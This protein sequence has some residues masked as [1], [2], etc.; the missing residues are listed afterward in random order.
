MASNSKTSTITI[1]REELAAS[2]DAASFEVAMGAIE[3]ALH[4]PILMRSIEDSKAK[5][6]WESRLEP[7]EHQVRNLITFCRRAPVALLADDVG[8]GKTIS[9]GL[10]LSELIARERV[11]RALIVAPKLLLPQWKEELESKFAIQAEAAAGAGVLAEFNGRATAVITT[12]HTFGKHSD[13]IA[14]SAFDMVVF[15]EAHKLRNLF[16]TAAPP[17][18][19]QAA[20]ACLR[21]RKFGYVLMLTA[22]PIQNRVW[23]LYSLVSLLTCANGH[24]NPLGTEAQFRQKFIVTEGG[25][26]ALNQRRRGEFQAEV[27]KYIARTRR[28]DVKLQFPER[29]VKKRAVLPTPTEKQLIQLIAELSLKQKRINALTRVNLGT[30]LMSSP[31]ALLAQLRNMAE[32]GTLPSSYADRAAA[33]VGEGTGSAKLNALLKLVGELRQHNPEHWR[34]VVFTSRKVTQD[35]IVASLEEAEI[36]VGA[37]RG[38][39]TAA[40]QA[41]IEAFR[42][43]PPGVRVL[44]SGE[45]GS[46]GVNLQVANVLVNF[47]LPWNPMT[48]EQRIGRVQRLHS[49]HAEVVVWNLV[50]EGTVEELVVEKLLHKLQEV[51][52]SIGDVEAILEAADADDESEGSLETQIADLVFRSLQGADVEAGVKAAVESIKKAKEVYKDEQKTVEKTLGDLSVFHEQGPALPDIPEFVPS[53]DAAAWVERAIVADGGR[54]SRLA[55]DLFEVR[56]ASGGGHVV[57][58]RESGVQQANRM[59]LAPVKELWPGTR[60]FV[61]LAQRVAKHGRLLVH[62]SPEESEGIIENA[63]R[64]WLTPYTHLRLGRVT[65]LQR[66]QRFAGELSIVAGAHTSYDRIERVVRATIGPEMLG[67]LAEGWQGQPLASSSQAAVATVHQ[68]DAIIAQA[69]EQ[70]PALSAF[71]SFYCQRLEQEVAVAA[72]QSAQYVQSK[73][74]VHRDAT[75]R[76]ARL[77]RVVHSSV[78]IVMLTV[79]GDRVETTARYTSAYAPSHRLHMEEDWDACELTRSRFPRSFLASCDVSGRRVAKSELEVCPVTGTRMCRVLMAP[80]EE[81][82]ELVNPAGLVRCET[83]GRTARGDLVGASAVSGKRCLLRLLEGCRFSGARCLPSELAVSEISDLAYRRDQESASSRSGLRGHL[84]EFV[85]TEEPEGLG[86]RSE[87]AQSSVS[88]RWGF[89]GDMVQSGTGSG[90]LG[91]PSE[92]IQCAATGVTVLRDEVEKSA[93][94]GLEAASTALV[95]CEL[96]GARCLPAE[97]SQSQIS[98]RLVRRDQLAVSVVTQLAGHVSEFVQTRRGPVEQSLAARSAVGGEWAVSAD[99]VSSDIDATRKAFSDQM[100]TSKSTGRRCLPDEAHR[101]EMSGCPGLPDEMCCCAVTGAKLLP[102]ETVLSDVS[103]C[104]VR[105][106]QVSKS[107]KSGRVGHQSEFVLC[108]QSNTLLAA[109]EAARS[110]YSGEWGDL[111]LMARSDVPPGRLGFAS[112]LVRSKASSRRAFPDEVRTSTLSGAYMLPDEGRQCSFTGALGLPDEMLQSEVSHGWYRRDQMV[113]C[114]ETGRCGHKSEFVKSSDPLGWIAKDAAV[115]SS[116]SGEWMARS[117]SVVS[118]TGSGRIG[119]K[120]EAA[121][122]AASGVLALRDEVAECGVSGK[123]VCRE[124]LQP[125]AASGTLALPDQMVTCAE[126]GNRLLPSETEVCAVSGKRVDLRRLLPS[127][128][129]GRLARES[130]MLRCPQSGVRLLPDEAVLCAVSGKRVAPKVAVVCAVSGRHAIADQ[131]ECCGVTGERFISDAKS[132]EVVLGRTGSGEITRECQWSGQRCLALRGATCVLTQLWVASKYLNATSELATLREVL[133]DSVQATVKPVTGAGLAA[134]QAIPGFPKDV[135]GAMALAGPGGRTAAVCAEIAG[136][137]LGLSKKHAGMIVKL[138]KPPAILGPVLIGKRA[139]GRWT[140]SS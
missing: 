14:N 21:D 133:D 62:D 127:D 139:K 76:A 102:E 124:L 25:K 38:G 67:A 5:R 77:A 140:R 64:E 87:V 113:R 31:G 137:F 85:K 108:K 84:S 66:E 18:M 22:T 86:A 129:S 74:L 78:Q 26:D 52:A 96:T 44:V 130:Q 116:V 59:G 119:L 121:K 23:D 16:G 11:K 45:T 42:S 15:D 17:Q 128:L 13:G 103:G 80:C 81:T 109:D 88:G 65:I 134:L 101:S 100:I 7:F 36:P 120:R 90:R 39:Q 68:A 89:R 10:I 126:S 50:L 72:P 34:V 4:K 27:G 117:R 46:E 92:I 71:V 107:G 61:Q 43:E 138:Q 83:S 112:E 47:D 40:N 122:C 1:K 82:G 28:Q 57:A 37:I 115:Q 97:L 135:A 3:W 79:G 6:T 48:L 32:G 9:A 51:V 132:R 70:D 56:Y 110:E 12:Y 53:Q 69:V 98:G 99:L 35:M 131:M 91:L 106:D 118:E 114:A 41:A 30:A 136:G 73:F 95:A 111:L 75:V 49:K 93:V 2:P 54:L 123:L 55:D 58:T 105:G 33:I 104:R 24:K 19:A 8:L 125:S 94:S 60:E 20:Q 29:S 63:V